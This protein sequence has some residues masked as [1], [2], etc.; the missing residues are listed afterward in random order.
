MDPRQAAASII[1]KFYAECN[2]HLCKLI[3]YEMGRNNFYESKE[4]DIDI[5]E[6]LNIDLP[7]ELVIDKATFKKIK[8]QIFN[9]LNFF[10]SIIQSKDFNIIEHYIFSIKDFK[11]TILLISP[12]KFPHG[13]GE[14]YFAEITHIYDLLGFDVIWL[15][16]DDNF[17]NEFN[18]YNMYGTNLKIINIK[19]IEE[20]DYRLI[21]E[22]KV[23]LI[24][25]IDNRYNDVFYDIAKINRVNLIIGFHFWG[26]YIDVNP[27]NNIQMKGNYSNLIKKDLFNTNNVSIYVASK[28]MLNKNI[29][30]LKSDKVKIINPI[31]FC[32][33]IEKTID[34]QLSSPNFK[35]NKKI[36][37]FAPN[38]P[39]GK[40]FIKQLLKYIDEESIEFV[41]LG[42]NELDVEELNFKS[43]NKLT[44]IRT[45]TD[46]EN[47]LKSVQLCVIPS[48]VDETF[49]RIYF[50]AIN[51][52]IPVISSNRGNLADLNPLALNNFHIINWIKRIQYVLE[53]EANYITYFT[54]QKNKIKNYL[55]RYE[56][57]TWK[58][59][60]DMAKVKTKVGIFSLSN[61]QGLGKYSKSLALSIESTGSEVVFFE[62]QSYFGE[63][64][65]ILKQE[66]TVLNSTFKV[67]VSRNKR[68]E[69]SVEELK[70]FIIENSIN[71]LIIPELVYL[72][73]WQRVF[74]LNL[75][76]LVVITIPM[77]EIVR[78]EEIKNYNKLSRTLFVTKQAETTMQSHGVK[79]G[80]FI[81]FYDYLNQHNW[82]FNE[83]E[84]KINK[85]QDIKVL[86]V[87]GYNA[88]KRK[89][90]KK[91]VS[92][93]IEL[94]K[95]RDD[96]R[97]T[98][99]IPKKEFEK[100]RLKGVKTKIK[101]IL[102]D[103]LDREINDL[104]F[105]SDLSIQMP[106]QE[107][108]GLGFYETLSSLTPMITLDAQP[109]SEIIKS[110]L[111]GYL[112]PSYR[113]ENVDND[114]GI[115]NGNDFDPYNLLTLLRSLSKSSIKT[116]IKNMSLNYKYSRLNYEIRLFSEIHIY[117]KP[118][119][120]NSE[121]EYDTNFLTLKDK[122]L[123]YVNLLYYLL[124]KK[125]LI[126]ASFDTYNYE[127][128]FRNY[129]RRIRKF[130]GRNLNI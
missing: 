25:L 86:H 45:Y 34:N 54:L 13:G 124:T 130:I 108:L 57:I 128:Y 43:K 78:K 66:F 7:K 114:M 65:D 58:N 91:I 30:A 85:S 113:I 29:S 64:N 15:S 129:I 94:E 24:H 70:S 119:E 100:L 23:T 84:L 14:S 53:N 102:N 39:K 38:Y 49:S 101:F 32:Q 95:Y 46:I 111:N 35:E 50:E 18:E 121:F 90:T 56:N 89:N 27:F 44:L 28:F 63:K 3:T 126:I 82:G 75:P 72:P 105:C 88:I 73:N 125:N 55:D 59:F 118:I 116:L 80:S 37:F 42:W 8:F 109:N 79:N 71:I 47:I 74:N 96:I 21:S 12:F 76:N 19:S 36:L 92:T 127:M 104:Y 97:L 10:L 61:N 112:V 68:E 107:G 117:S 77:V 60:F 62:F 51:F 40:K 6:I 5:V 9:N 106:F 20:F 123:N 31:P 120:Q 11:S 83:K 99:T 2:E 16:I 115:V 52:G 110:N 33:Y 93:F 69:V 81:G 26:N 17:S 98:V 103:L 41:L 22:Y 67:H 87:A 4:I 1:N 122:L 48:L